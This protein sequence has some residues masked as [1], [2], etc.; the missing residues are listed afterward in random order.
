MGTE[1]TSRLN[2]QGP[3]GRELPGGPRP[4]VSLEKSAQGDLWSWTHGAELSRPRLVPQVGARWEGRRGRREGLSEEKTGGPPVVTHGARETVRC[5]FRSICSRTRCWTLSEP[6]RKTRR[7]PKQRDCS[8]GPAH[9]GWRGQPLGHPCPPGTPH[10]ASCVSG[11]TAVEL[12]QPMTDVL[13]CAEQPWEPQGRNV[14]E[15]ARAGDLSVRG[16]PSAGN[17]GERGHRHRH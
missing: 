7:Q 3:F 8:R 1:A 16:G 11:A 15:R 14:P 17:D 9:G 2:R 13:L 6:T 5:L 4:V 10:Q 12:G